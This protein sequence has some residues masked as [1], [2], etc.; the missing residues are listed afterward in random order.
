MD[1]HG[2]NWRIP[3]IFENKTQHC[4]LFSTKTNQGR[5]Y[6]HCLNSLSRAKDLAAANH[7]TQAVV[8]VESIRLGLKVGFK[9]LRLE[10]KFLIEGSGLDCKDIG[11]RKN[12]FVAKT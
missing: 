4:V 8:R 1:F 5:F 7:V 10:S 11:I 2:R 6:F 12:K 9:E 3:G